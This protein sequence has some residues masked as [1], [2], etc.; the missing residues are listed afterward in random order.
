M[1]SLL[2]SRLFHMIIPLICDKD[3][4]LFYEPLDLLQLLHLSHALNV[5][6]QFICM[7]FDSTNVQS[8]EWCAVIFKFAKVI[9][10]QE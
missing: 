4:W 10:S 3:H 5:M 2:V 1:S 8:Y 7:Q 6:D 9:W